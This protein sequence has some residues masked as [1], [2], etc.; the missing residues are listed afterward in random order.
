VAGEGG[1]GVLEA[2]AEVVGGERSGAAKPM[3]ALRRCRVREAGV[4]AGG[5]TAELELAA[6][7]TAGL[8]RRRK[9]DMMPGWGVQSGPRVSRIVEADRSLSDSSSSVA[10]DAGVS[11]DMG[12]LTP[13][14]GIV[15]GNGRL[16]RPAGRRDGPATGSDMGSSASVGSLSPST[17]RR[18][19]PGELTLVCDELERSRL[20]AFWFSW[21]RRRKVDMRR[22]S[23]GRR[24]SS[25]C[26]RAGWLWLAPMAG[27]GRGAE[28]RSD[29]V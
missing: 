16:G 27:E 1:C 24:S 4:G 17:L 5:G 19:G 10:G 20:L 8:S 23:V 15:L 26:L 25:S 11:G 3:M 21:S 14:L 28:G 22:R 29:E 9:R 12:V 7:L 6:L 18:L 2:G 13:L